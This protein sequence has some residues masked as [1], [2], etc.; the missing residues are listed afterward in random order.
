MFARV[1]TISGGNPANVDESIA[2]ARDQI[3]PRARQMEGW[4]SVLS[5][6]DRS[7]GEGLLITLW[8]TEEAMAASAQHAQDLRSE[9]SRSG[10]TEAD[11]HGYE[12]MTLETA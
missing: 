2:F 5:L 9:S 12:V 8:E 6:A 11:V 3:L 1:T 10:E 4:R 7:S